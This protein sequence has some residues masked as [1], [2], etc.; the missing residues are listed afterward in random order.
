VAA[1]DKDIIKITFGAVLFDYCEYYYA[2]RRF[3]RLKL[4]VQKTLWTSSRCFVSIFQYNPH[5]MLLVNLNH[6]DF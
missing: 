2:V 5:V 3:F 6:L 1:T 4:N